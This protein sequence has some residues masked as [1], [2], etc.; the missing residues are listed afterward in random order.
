M[1][2][3]ILIR[4]DLKMGKGKLCSQA[5]HASIASFL[6]ADSKIRERWLEQGMKK[7]IL[8]VSSEKELKDFCRK[9]AKEKIP[10]ELIM[11]AGLTQV[12]QGTVTALGIGPES[13]GK[14]DSL[15]SKLKLL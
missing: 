6:K 2:Q 15:T 3:A 8:K 1:K 12:E 13:D 4:T 5:C 14:I 10:C 7:V 9:A 11:D